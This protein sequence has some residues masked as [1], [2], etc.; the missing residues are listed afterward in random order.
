[1][2]LVYLLPYVISSVPTRPRKPQLTGYFLFLDLVSVNVWENPKR[3][4]VSKTLR[5]AYLAL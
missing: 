2:L 5:P 3:S 1:M 4:A